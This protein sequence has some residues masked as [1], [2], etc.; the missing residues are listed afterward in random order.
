MDTHHDLPRECR[1]DTVVFMCAMHS[2]NMIRLGM[3]YDMRVVSCSLM[4]IPKRLHE[5]C[6]LFIDAFFDL[7]SMRLSH[8]DACCALAR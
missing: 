1:L 8:I 5:G 3:R 7:K 4:L 6:S 2:A